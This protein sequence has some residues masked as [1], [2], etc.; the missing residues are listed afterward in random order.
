[1]NSLALRG[2]VFLLLVMTSY[3][4]GKTAD[5]ATETTQ[6]FSDQGR[7]FPVMSTEPWL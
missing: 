1:M 5:E 3:A 7:G 2:F 4:G 6:W